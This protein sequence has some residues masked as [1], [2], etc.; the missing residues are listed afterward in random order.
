MNIFYVSDNRTTA[1]WGCRATSMALH[2]FLASED[3]VIGT[4]YNDLKKSPLLANIPVPAS[5]ITATDEYFGKGR[6]GAKVLK[7]LPSLGERWDFVSQDS[8]ETARRIVKQSTRFK[9]LREIVEL[10]DRCDA[11]VINGEGN[12]IFT[13]WRRSL[14]FLLG[15]AA[16]GKQMGRRVIFSNA[17]ISDHPRVPRD[18]SIFAECRRVLGNCDGVL[19]RDPQSF[20]IATEEMG[21]SN[22]R[23]AP[24]ALF[25]WH[26]Q[27]ESLGIPL[28]SLG[29]IMLPFGEEKR[30]GE[31][32]FTAPYIVL[33][34]SSGAR[35]LDKDEMTQRYER[36]I[37]GFTAQGHA[38]CLF[39]ACE[40]DRFLRRVA[41]KTGTPLI[42]V[43]T[44][45]LLACAALGNAQAIVSGRYHP[46]IMASLGGT[47]AIGFGSNS[48]KMLSLQRV[49]GFS[50]P[51]EF[52]FPPKAGDIDQIVRSTLDLVGAGSE[53][54]DRILTRAR[55][56]AAL[57]AVE[58]RGMI[59]GTPA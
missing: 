31:L 42:P 15:V 17:M 8:E 55:E 48:H 2:E 34:G 52:G 25:L 37:A 38:V 5:W 13:P 39:E 40:G 50:D 1:N 19:V 6:M 43:S 26:K 3:L 12:V 23:Y 53:L 29:R 9:E 58:T 44:P 21:L 33:G 57:F 54:R 7:H 36:L 46:T 41:S 47:P 49:L 11:V 14:R 4:L 30:F 10:I 20:Q 59:A 24:D 45:I 35:N 56:N 18:P 27:V 32:D 51:K 28:Q 16:L 22:V